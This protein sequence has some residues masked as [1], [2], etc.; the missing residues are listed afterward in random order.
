VF[1]GVFLVRFDGRLSLG[2]SSDFFRGYFE[3]RVAEGARLFILD[4]SGLEWIDSAGLSYLVAAFQRVKMRVG[5]TIL[6]NPQA[7]LAVL[8]ITR[9]EIIFEYADDWQSGFDKILGQPT[10]LP[11]FKFT[12]WKPKAVQSEISVRTVP[13]NIS[14]YTDADKPL[15]PP[16]ERLSIK[17]MAGVAAGALLTLALIVAGLVWVA[18]EINSVVLL[19]LIFSVAVLF[20][21][22]IIGLLLLLSG[23]LSE[24]ASE[25]LFSGVLGKIPGLGTL[26]ARAPRVRAKN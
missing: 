13:L 23:H 16:V 12:E 14:P 22:C 21:T 19:V 17:G 3:C 9:L 7:I 25:K 10:Q 5:R 4:F 11:K 8:Q 1:Q 15:D 6:V 2:E 24:K 20:S 26:A 18:K